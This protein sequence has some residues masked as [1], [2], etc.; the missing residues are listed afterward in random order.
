[1][2]YSNPDEQH[3]REIAE[4]KHKERLAKS[5]KLKEYKL[6]VKNQLQKVAM[7]KQVWV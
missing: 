5:N 6:K 4:Q 7:E 3:D 1:V 2:E